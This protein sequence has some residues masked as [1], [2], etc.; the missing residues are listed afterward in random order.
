MFSKTNV[1]K[2][3][4]PPKPK[5][6]LGYETHLSFTMLMYIE[7]KLPLRFICYACDVPL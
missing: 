2:A 1:L 6:S 7:L 3:A 4:R 5:S